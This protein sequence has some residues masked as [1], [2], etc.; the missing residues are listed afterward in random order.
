MISIFVYGTLKQ[1]HCNHTHYCRSAVSIETASVWGR[2]Y[3]LP[4]GYPGLIVPRE[5]ILATGTTN[6]TADAN[7]QNS[8]KLEQ[9]S[10]TKPTGDWDKITG[11]LITFAAPETDLPPIDRLE[12][13]NPGG[14][15][16]YER[17]LVS[18]AAD[19]DAKNVWLYRYNLQHNGKRIASGCWQE[20][21]N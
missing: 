21:F 19:N 15:S 14:W 2:L 16:L 7:L 1:G 13:F 17:V 8:T 10:L 18:V 4:E 6:P 3:S 5:S 12:A 9:Q 11:E 20:S